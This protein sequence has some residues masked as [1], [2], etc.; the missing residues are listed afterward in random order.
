MDT[1]DWTIVFQ[2]RR[3]WECHEQAL[4]LDAL[5]IPHLIADGPRNA[6]LLLVPADHAVRAREELRLYA[7]ENRRTPPRPGLTLHGYGLPG[8][9]GYVLVLIAAFLVQGRVA[10]GID[11]LN[12]G[13]LDGAAFR[14]GEWW[15][16]FTAL[17]L[18]GDAGHLVANLFFGAF[19]G[20]FAGQF[21]GSGVAWATIL[22]AAGAGNG[23]DLFLLPA[24][25][26]AIGASTG[27]FAALGL[28]A[29]LMWRAEARRTSS[30]A[31]RY[32]PLIGAAVLLAYI[33]TGDAQTDAVAHLTGF[34]AGVFAGAAFDV[35]RPRWLQF[36]AVQATAGIATLALLATC[37]WLAVGA[38]RGGLA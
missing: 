16:V 4:V 6:A 11:W 13:S 30:W 19:F 27:V 5:G 36:R 23:L 32:A 33:G 12:A 10:F 22:L 8:V 25:H 3:R 9:A 29:A 35:R 34:I 18:H 37:W 24:S 7:A 2:T 17:T 31:R 21:L 1:H 14:G 28:I 15:R 38:W 20:A 26:R